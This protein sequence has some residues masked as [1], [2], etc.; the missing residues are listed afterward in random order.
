MLRVFSTGRVRQ[1]L[2]VRGV[3]RYFLDRWSD[4]TLPVNVFLIEHPAGL[5]LVDTGQC[6]AAAQPGYFPSW[7]P[8]FRLARFE[9]GT[10]DEAA[11]QLAGAGYD[12]ARIRWVVLTH[13]HTDHV[14]GIGAFP[15]AEVIVSRSEWTLA[16]GLGGRL[17]G[18]LPQYWPEPIHPH[19][20]DFTGPPIGPFPGSYDVASDGRLLLVP[21][22]GHT[23]GHAALLVRHDANQAY[24]CAGDAAHTAAEFARVEPMIAAW[25]REENV[26]VL[27][28]HDDAASRLIGGTTTGIA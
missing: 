9:L 24:L 26:M 25:C 15:D 19:V 2:G 28:S 3:G 18:Y 12:P 5:C 23:G 17:R 7:Y 16:Q 20:V 21:L 22:P 6:A 1:K 8:F 4:A 10:A 14:G 13:M 27:T 11:A